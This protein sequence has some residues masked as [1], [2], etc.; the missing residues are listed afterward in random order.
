LYYFIGRQ[1][2]T[3]GRNEQAA[4]DSGVF[5]SA[6]AALAE[7]ETYFKKALA[8]ND[9]YARGHIGLAGVYYQR[10]Q[11]QSIEERLAQPE[12][13]QAKQH[14]QQA[15]DYALASPEG[16]AEL[17]ARFGLNL[18]ARLQGVTYRDLDFP[19]EAE[20]SFEFAIREMKTLLRP[21]AEEKQQRT[22]A[23]AYLALG[24]TLREYA[25]LRQKQEDKA[26]SIDLYR[27]AEEAFAG[28]LAQGD[29]ALGGNPNDQLIKTI[30]T[31]YC[32]P[33][34]Q[35]VAAVRTI[36]EGE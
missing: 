34:Q 28:C 32:Q 31:E 27:Q 14:Y 6:A 20:A 13:E 35:Q 5:Q 18:V 29:L 24:V 2:L 3:L 11:S 16:P 7:A 4:Q 10:A 12:L 8:S 25:E 17:E 30:I 1:A 23:Q 15:L 26:G 19:I 21:L 36:L 22:L 9:K 33:H